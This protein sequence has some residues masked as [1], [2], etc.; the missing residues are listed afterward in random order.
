VHASSVARPTEKPRAAARSLKT[1][2]RTPCRRAR[3]R[4]LLA[5][6]SV[7]VDIVLGEPDGPTARLLPSRGPTPTDMNC[8]LP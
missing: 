6:D 4:R 3:S 8:R 5:D 1:Q 2:Q 7:E